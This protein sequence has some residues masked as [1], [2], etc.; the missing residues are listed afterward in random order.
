M[1]RLSG[2][3][4][5]RGF[6][7]RGPIPRLIDETNRGY[8]QSARGFCDSGPKAF[9]YELIAGRDVRTRDNLFLEDRG[10]ECS[11]SARAADTSLAAHGVPTSCAGLSYRPEPQLRA[12]SRRHRS[13]PLRQR[14]TR[15]T[16]FRG[17]DDRELESSPDD[18]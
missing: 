5:G 16:P 4:A 13:A 1:V 2:S 8:L 10:L 9:H 12:G 18:S 7:D 14:S 15:T 6:Q 17:Q 11:I 3:G